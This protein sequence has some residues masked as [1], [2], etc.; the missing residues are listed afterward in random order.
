[1]VL[2]RGSQVYV[3]SASIAAPPEMA[4]YE[5]LPG[6]AGLTPWEYQYVGQLDG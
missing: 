2:L 3:G 5:R 4:A 6:H 1:M